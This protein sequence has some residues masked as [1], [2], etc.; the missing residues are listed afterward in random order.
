MKTEAKKGIIKIR[1]IGK[2][3]IGLTL[4][5]DV[6]D[7]FK[8]EEGHYKYTASKDGIRIEFKNILNERWE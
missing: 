2:S 4:P 1:K 8:I 6:I 3:S 5:K 7:D